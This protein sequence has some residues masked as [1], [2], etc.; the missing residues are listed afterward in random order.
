MDADTILRIKPALTRYLHEFDDCFGRRQT[1]GHLDTYVRGQLGEL[2]PESL[3]TAVHIGPPFS[4]LEC[5]DELR[6]R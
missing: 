4:S 2:M 3:R 5:Q 1:R 6:R